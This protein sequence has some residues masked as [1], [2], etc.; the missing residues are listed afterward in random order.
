MRK[1]PKDVLKMASGLILPSGLAGHRRPLCIAMYFF[2]LFFY[3]V[4][5]NLFFEIS[6]RHTLSTMTLFY[7][8]GECDG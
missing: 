8:V 4:L 2:T 6:S 7:N 5:D 3:Y 1:L